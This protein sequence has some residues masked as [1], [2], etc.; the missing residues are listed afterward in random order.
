[1]VGKAIA[2]Q[3]TEARTLIDNSR[4]HEGIREALTRFGYPLKNIDKG[5]ALLEEFVTLHRAKKTNYGARFSATDTVRTEWQQIKETYEEHRTIA[6][7][8][9]KHD[10]GTQE[11]LELNT[12][13]PRRRADQNEQLASFYA[14]IEQHHK[15]M[16][17]YGITK[18]ALEQAQSMMMTFIQAQQQQQQK[19]G[20]AQSSTRR[21][22]DALKKLQRWVRGYRAIVRVALEEQPQLLEVLG[23]VV[24]G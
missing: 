16:Q 21:R 4:N 19:T 10:R 22:N 1:M 11:A 7:L 18:T 17:R 15:A 14:K 13:L 9:F 8:V 12:P 20:E 6:R 3:I 24:R 5:H 23:T 2:E